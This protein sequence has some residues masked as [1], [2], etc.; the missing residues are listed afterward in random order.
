[1]RHV[2]TTAH[3]PGKK[4]F[5][6]I[7]H[8]YTTVTY[9]HRDLPPP[10]KPSFQALPS[11]FGGPG[12]VSAGAGCQ[13][14][15]WEPRA[16]QSHPRCLCP[17]HPTPAAA[18]ANAEWELLSGSEAVQLRGSP[19]PPCPAARR[20]PGGL[21]EPRELLC[22]EMLATGTA[23]TVFSLV[24]YPGAIAGLCF[25]KHTHKSTSLHH[26]GEVHGSRGVV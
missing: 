17:R 9:L 15:G 25:R 8:A 10:S 19:S 23:G 16:T 13:R 3:G 18:F 12:V 2:E 26:A 21:A 22:R 7:P 14:Q 24:S 11:S 6:R 1:M 20:V 5:H 4:L